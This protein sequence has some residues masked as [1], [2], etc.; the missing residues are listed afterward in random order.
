[1]ILCDYRNKDKWNLT[2]FHLTEFN[3]LLWVENKSP[4]MLMCLNTQS[5]V[6]DTDCICV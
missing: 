6:D 3:S 5:L 2:N 1:M 4:T